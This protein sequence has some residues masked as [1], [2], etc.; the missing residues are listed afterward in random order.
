MSGAAEST[1]DQTIDYLK[2]RRQ[3]GKLIGAYQSLKHPTVDNFVAWEQAR[4]HLYAA[5]HCF[6]EQGTGEV[7]TRMAKVATLT[8]LANAADRAIQFH[9]GFGF[10]FECDAHLFRRRAI[11]HG[12]VSGDAAEHKRR[13]ADLLLA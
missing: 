12:A 6:G 7:A 10:T 9:G 4:S 1:L 5:A 11:W 13:L 8:A 3:F 2:T